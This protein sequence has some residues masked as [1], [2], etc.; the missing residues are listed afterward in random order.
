MGLPF[1]L[2]AYSKARLDVMIYSLKRVTHAED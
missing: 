1:G 2:K